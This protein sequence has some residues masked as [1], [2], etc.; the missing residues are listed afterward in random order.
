MMVLF[1]G[2]AIFF[3]SFSILEQLLFGSFYL[4]RSTRLRDDAIIKVT[5]QRKNCQKT[6]GVESMNNHLSFL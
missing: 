2:L 5:N 6:V 3:S 1:L 4:F